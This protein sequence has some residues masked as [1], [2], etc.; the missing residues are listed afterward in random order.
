M[1][2]WARPDD[3]EAIFRL[4]RRCFDDAFLDFTIYRS[5]AA[6]N[7]LKTV[8]ATQPSTP[9]TDVVRVLREGAEL[10]AYYMAGRHADAF[11]LSYIGADP[12]HAAHGLG[13]RMMADFEDLAVSA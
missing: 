9:I 5:D 12:S 1:I 8:I 6:V 7:H 13:R 2:D 10:L 11:H 4:K 3:A